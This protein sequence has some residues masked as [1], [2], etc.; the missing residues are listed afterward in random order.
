LGFAPTYRRF[1]YL[2]AAS[3]L[4]APAALQ[5]Q[6]ADGRN[7]PPLAASALAAAMAQY[8]RALAEYM[9]A[10]ASYAAATGAYWSSIAEK[11]RLR[12]TKRVNHEPISLDDYVLA[13]PPVYAGPP[14]PRNP[15]KPSEEAPPAPAIYVPVV[16][17][18]LAAAQREF[19][20]VP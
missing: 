20:F 6:P 3:I 18:F 4:L 2:L 13:Q 1:R 17:D 10:Q 19:K 11:R 8:R 5:A 9:E 7:Q 16:A 12:A 15:S 14:R